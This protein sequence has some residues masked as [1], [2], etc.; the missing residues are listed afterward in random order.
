[1][2]R[3]QRV[4]GPGIIAAGMTLCAVGCE[5]DPLYIDCPM[6]DAIKQACA[7]QQSTTQLT[8][9]VEQH[10]YCNEAICAMWQG[11]DPFCSRTCSGDGD[12]PSG[13]TCQTYLD[14]NFC[15]Q[16]SVTSQ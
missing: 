16:D 13:S 8:C 4:L 9:V 3:L 5:A 11:S 6:S 2:G 1:M 12:C 10:P 15:V 14:I 7:S